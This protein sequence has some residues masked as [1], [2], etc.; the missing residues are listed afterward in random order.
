VSGVAIE[1]CIVFAVYTM[2]AGAFSKLAN[3]GPK[4]VDGRTLAFYVSIPDVGRLPALKHAVAR[5]VGVS[6]ALSVMTLVVELGAVTAVFLPAARLPVIVALLTL[7]AGIWLTMRPNYLPQSI[8]YL[9]WLPWAGAAVGDGAGSLS[10]AATA[11]GAALVTTIS[12]VL[13][14]CAIL[15]IDRWPL[16]SIPM[17]S[18]YRGGFDPATLADEQQLRQVVDEQRR[19]AYSHVIGWPARWV[20]ACVQLAP[21]DGKAPR[22]AR[23]T[24]ARYSTAAC[25]PSS[26][27]GASRTP[28]SRPWSSRARAPPSCARSPPLRCERGCASPV[29]SWARRGAAWR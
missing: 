26:I 9:L 23:S 27:S 24:C 20:G 1:L 25:R 17:Y 19:R 3:S 7:H 15:R 28:R 8:C 18:F 11:F 21:A 4:W 29:A 12:V 13:L 5:N 10:P 22:R 14:A 6:R 16:T 2:V